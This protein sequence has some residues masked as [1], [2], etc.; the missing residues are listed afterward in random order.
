MATK[1]CILNGVNV[2][3]IEDQ[4]PKKRCGHLGDKELDTLDGYCQTLRSANLAAQELLGPGQAN[5]QWVRIVAR[6][7]ALSAKRMIY[8]DK[9]R[10][11]NHPDHGFI[12]WERGASDDG[13]YLYIKTGKQPGNWKSMG[14]RIGC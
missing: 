7:D 9:L 2:L 11:S 10:D 4:G 8:S 3:H 13:K 5:Q 1:E 6:T 14:I 12:D